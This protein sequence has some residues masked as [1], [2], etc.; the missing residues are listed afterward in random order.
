MKIET[1]AEIRRLF[2]CER[3]KRRAIAKKLG[4][5][6]DTVR[7]AL[8]MKTFKPP[9]WPRR[10]S[11]LDPFKPSIAK[12][13]EK[14]PKLSAMRIREE[15]EKEGYRGGLTI[16]RAH[17]AT[18]RPRQ[19]EVFA[20]CHFEPGEAFQVDWAACGTLLHEGVPRRLWAFLM[21]AC[22]SRLLYV[23]FTLSATTDD[24][25]RCHQN[26]FV[27]YGGCFRYG[28]YDNLKS[29][30]LFH[31][32]KEIRFNPRFQEFS[33]FYLFEP[34]ICRV[35]QPQEKSRV[36]NSVRYL[37]LSFL[38][39]REFQ[40]FSELQIEAVRWRDQVANL[41][42]HRGTLKRPVELFSEEKPQLRALPVQP[43]DT[44]ITRTLKGTHQCRVHFE[45]NTYSI[46][47]EYAGQTLTLKASPE[48]LELFAA[49]ALV[50]AHRRSWGRGVDVV[51]PKH[52]EAL[53]QKK[54]W[55][56]QSVLEREF[57]QL[58]PEAGKYLA[59]LTRA[60]IN[61]FVHM[62]KILELAS[63]YG[64]VEVA[65]AL[66]RA[67]RHEAFGF[68]YIHNIVQQE[69]R[70]RHRPLSSELT[71]PKLPGKE[72]LAALSFEEG[73]LEEYDKFL[74]ERSDDDHGEAACP[75]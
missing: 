46:P 36:E 22:Y 17:V 66:E 65:Q 14:F 40:D 61:P 11:C 51:E 4:V 20:V 45:G 24:F 74:E 43:F 8:A 44:R 38:A 41:R 26:A 52:E 6:R 34:R 18:V 69:R 67:L 62:R 39:G 16:L 32:G 2:F 15:I 75:A 27:F 71:L 63:L 72:D 31:L 1:W 5:C 73:S 56:A 50:A 19:R 60:A 21:V 10:P 49:E 33:G 54:R 7:R 3:L 9:T 28:M 23:E 55:L 58:S 29:A 13:L 35:R 57:R 12:L 25:L 47:A 59:G 30:V 70:Q 53:R 42:L 68:D 37:R 64:Q 48:R